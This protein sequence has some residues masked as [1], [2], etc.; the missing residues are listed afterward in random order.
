MTNIK[1]CPSKELTEIVGTEGHKTEAGNLVELL[2]T[3]LK[4]RTML[5]PFE[6][7]P[8]ALIPIKY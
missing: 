8:P 5:Q 6:I 4:E 7:T 3:I 1:L 2:V